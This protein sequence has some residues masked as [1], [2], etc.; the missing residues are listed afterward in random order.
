[1]IIDDEPSVVEQDSK[2]EW[3]EAQH[4]SFSEES[5]LEEPKRN[6]M[7]EYDKEIPPAVNSLDE[8]E[9]L[10]ILETVPEKEEVLDD[11][12]LLDIVE[13]ETTQK[14]LFDSHSTENEENIEK[15]LELLKDG[16]CLN[17]L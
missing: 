9:A 16:L 3:G 11:D 17:Q 14:P 7:Q 8:E 6:L 13:A 10:R 12:A 4:T 1:M 2:Q 5:M 15:M